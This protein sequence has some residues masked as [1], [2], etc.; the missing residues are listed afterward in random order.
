[1]TCRFFCK[2]HIAQGSNL[3][4][5]PWWRQ[6]II[7]ADFLVRISQRK[8]A[9][10]ARHGTARTGICGSL[11]LKICTIP[12]PYVFMIS[13]MWP[14]FF[15]IVCGHLKHTCVESLYS[16][17]HIH[18]CLIPVSYLYMYIYHDPDRS[19][20]PSIDLASYLSIYLSFYLSI[21]LSIYLPIYLSICNVI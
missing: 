12:Y 9:T 16:R 15:L 17:I 6:C 2:K 10:T 1:M 5:T 21:Y 7:F 20:H 3:T 13:A 4:L 8:E 11:S 18:I 14:L 19:I